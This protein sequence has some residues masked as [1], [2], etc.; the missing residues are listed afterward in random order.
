MSNWW[1]DGV[2]PSVTDEGPEHVD[3]AA[4]E[5]EHGLDVMLALGSLAV[6]ETAGVGIPADADHGGLEEDTLQS[7]V[8]PPGAV[9]VL[10]D[11]A[12][13]FW[14]GCH[15]GEGRQSVSGGEGIQAAAG[16]GEELRSEDRPDAG[17]GSDHLG[18]FV[19][20]KPSLDEL[21]GLGDLLVEGHYL[22]RQGVDHPRDGLLP[23]NGGVLTVSG[24][25]C[26]GR[27]G[28]GGADLAVAQP[29]RKASLARPADRHRCLIAREQNQSAGGAHVEGTFQGRETCR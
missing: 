11:L 29:R 28:V 14:R 17:H 8:I 16:R 7:S 1:C 12:G 26:F 22:L 15:P 25:Q 18:E 6:V 2:A 21:V 9:V 13:V 27:D 4:G 5:S 24:I 19:F 3:T 10:A 20:A 23:G